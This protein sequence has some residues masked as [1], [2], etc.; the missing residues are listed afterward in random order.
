MFALNSNV[1]AFFSD[2][3]DEIRL[4]MP[5]KKIDETD[6]IPQDGTCIFL[7]YQKEDTDWLVKTALYVDGQLRAE[8]SGSAPVREESALIEKK[9]KKRFLK[10]AVYELL[11]TYFKQSPPWG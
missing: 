11:K 3:C 5:A 9:Y 6:T 10:N 8:H 1:P 4:F 7:R 2:L